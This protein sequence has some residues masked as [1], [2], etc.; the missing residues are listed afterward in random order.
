MGERALVQAPL[1]RAVL[2]LL[3]EAQW[4]FSTGPQPAL[5]LT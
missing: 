4:P 3:S 2:T 1:A 5:F